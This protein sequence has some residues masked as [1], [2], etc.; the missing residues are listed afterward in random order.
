ML[1]E[2]KAKKIGDAKVTALEY[3]PSKKI[4]IS[5]FS[6]Q[7]LLSYFFPGDFSRTELLCSGMLILEN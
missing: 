2:K 3:L 6:V 7:T 5:G 4:F 1:P